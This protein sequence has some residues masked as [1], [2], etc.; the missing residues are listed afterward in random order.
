M[1]EGK[2]SYL[3]FSSSFIRLLI[4]FIKAPHSWLNHFLKSSPLKTFTLAIQFQHMNFERHVQI[5]AP[6]HHRAILFLN[7]VAHIMKISKLYSFNW[8]LKYSFCKSLFRKIRIWAPP[9]KQSFKVCTRIKIVQFEKEISDQE[10]TSFALISP[11]LI[12][13]GIGF[14]GLTVLNKSDIKIRN[15]KVTVCNALFHT[16]WDSVPFVICIVFPAYNLQ[17]SNQLNFQLLLIFFRRI[18]W[19]LFSHTRRPR[20]LFSL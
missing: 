5:T 4:W 6:L 20:S 12:F 15:E 16:V 10:F 7:L 13:L 9:S 17:S 18:V 11:F 2:I 3:V 19:R 1:S 14:H 8:C